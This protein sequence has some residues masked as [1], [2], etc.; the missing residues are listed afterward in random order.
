MDIAGRTAF[1]TGAG[2]G[3]GAALA[4]EL[5]AAGAN[6]T[7]SGR[8]QAALGMVADRI[9]RRCGA[10]PRTCVLDLASVA[11][12]DSTAAYADVDI[13]INNGARWLEG[14][15]ERNSPADIAETV[16]SQLTGTILLTRAFLPVLKSKSRADILNIVSISGLPNMPL[17]GASVAFYAAKH[18]QA[19]FSDGLREELLGTPVRVTA[20][21]PPDLDD[22]QPGTPEW[23][24]NGS[25]P[26]SARVTNRDIVEIALFALSRPPHVCLANVA[27]D[28]DNGGRFGPFA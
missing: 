15:L 21:H 19:G 25:R 4:E 3:L 20:I 24:S 8:N 1:I 9:A 14:S 5:A 26:K 10:R 11:P 12:F 23:E 27:V 13:L 6:V 28:A 2:R 17:H 16:A 7:L 22:I 18:G